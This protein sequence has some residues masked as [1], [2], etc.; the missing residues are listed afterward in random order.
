MITGDL[1]PFAPPA[2]TNRRMSRALDTTL[3]RIAFFSLLLLPLLLLHAHGIAE[4]AIGVADVCFLLRSVL[5]GDWRWL[6]TGW[7]WVAGAWWAWLV[8][9][10]LPIPGTDLGEGGSRSFVQAIA[11]VRFLILVAAMQHMVLRTPRARR[12]LQRLITA[13]AAWIVLNSLVQA[14]VGKNLIGWPPAAE[15]LPNSRW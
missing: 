3:E 5:T 4:L 14:I 1:L 12:W 11:T 7:V 6:R 10:S 13:S 8:V 2:G 9:C 15:G